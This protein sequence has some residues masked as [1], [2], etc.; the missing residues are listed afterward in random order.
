MEA[1]ENKTVILV[2]HQVEFL[3]KVDKILVS[4]F[5]HLYI[6]LKA[7]TYQR[8]EIS[9][10]FP[11]VM[12]NGEI[13]QEGTYQELL[14]SG[15]AFEQLVNAHR[16][17]KTPLDSQD[18]GKG[19]KEPGPFQCQIPMIPRNSETEISTGNLQSVQLTEEEKRELGEAGL[20]PYKDYVSVSKGWFLLVLIILAQC[21]FVV[22][23]CL[24]TYWLAI[25]VQNHQFSVAVVVGVYAVMATASCLF[26]YIRSLLAA[27][28]G[29]KASRKFF[30]GLMDSVFKA[31][32]LFFD[33]TPIGRIMTRVKY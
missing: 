28:F 17:S 2:T 6:T 23:Q 1:L 33:S 7:I 13:T 22:L 30:S 16:D 4:E 3:S 20:K 24:A 10:T 18:H 8:T 19:A 31:P 9:L 32:M 11:Q 26:A 29:L 21:A 27:H 5:W 25:A 15:T 14:Q 12:E